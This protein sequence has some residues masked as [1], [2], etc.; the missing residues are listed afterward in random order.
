MA[1]LKAIAKTKRQT[2]KKPEF[3]SFV[4]W[5]NRLNPAKPILHVNGPSFASA[6]LTVDFGA[7]LNEPVVLTAEQTAELVTGLKT[8]ARSLYRYDVN[9]RVQNDLSNGIWWASIN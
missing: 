4:Q 3:E 7:P 5:L 1:D 6:V 9:V 8:A 2:H